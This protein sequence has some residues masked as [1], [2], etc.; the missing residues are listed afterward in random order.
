MT[1]DNL[2][3][4]LDPEQRTATLATG[5]TVVAAGAGS[6]KTRVLTAR[7]L[8]L[9]LE[10]GLPIDKVLALTFTQKAAAEMKSRIHKTLRELEHPLARSVLEGFH[11]AR[12]STID[13]LC[14]AI[15]RSACRQWGIPPDFQ[16][17]DAGARDA[18][19]A[20]AL[21]FVLR[22]RTHPAIKHLLF[23]TE[24]EKIAENLFASLVATHS[25]I[26][27]PIDFRTLFLKQDAEVH[28]RIESAL[29]EASKVM[30]EI[31]RLAQ[32]PSIKTM[33]SIIPISVLT[34]PDT[35]A[36]NNTN[37]LIT[38]RT[39]LSLFAVAP[40]R[41]GTSKQPEAQAIKE[42]L[43]EVRNRHDMECGALISFVLNRDVI[44]GL[45]TLLEEFQTLY[46]TQK[47]QS[48]RLSFA[49]VAKMAVDALATDPELRRSWKAGVDAIMID[50]FQDNN[51]LQRDLLF[52]LAENSTR[53]ETGIPEPKDLCSD[54]LFFVGDEKQSI[55]RFRGADVAVFRALARDLGA[56]SRTLPVLSTNYRTR[57]SLLHQFNMIFPA[58]FDSAGTAPDWE[59]RFTCIQPNRPDYDSPEPIQI[60]VMDHM[61][62]DD[63][64][65]KIKSQIQEAECV[66]RT[67]Q[68]LIQSAVPVFDANGVSH[69]CRADDCAI[70][71]RSTTNQMLFEHS[72]RAAGIPYQ[73]EN[74]RGLFSDAPVN[75]LAALLRTVANPLDLK[76][77]AIVL[78]SPFACL[79]GSGFT[80]A[81]SALKSRDGSQ[82][83]EPA[84][85]SACVDAL[86]TGEDCEQW[87]ALMDLFS[88]AVR[89]ADRIPISE[90]LERLWY[91]RGY[92][93]K[94]LSDPAVR[95]LTALFDYLFELARQADQDGQTLGEFLDRIE[96]I[97][98]NEEKID[99]LDIPIERTGGVRLMTIHKS[100][101]LEFPIVFLANCDTT[102]KN[103]TNSDLV[104]WS[105]VW[106]PT[107]NVGPARKVP[108]K[109]HNWFYL[110][111]KAE[112]E[113]K[114]LAELRRLLYVGMTRAESRLYL[115]GVYKLGGD[116]QESL[117]KQMAEKKPK[118]IKSFFDLF[119][120]VLSLPNA[121]GVQVRAWKE[122]AIKPAA[123]GLFGPSVQDMRTTAKTAVIQQWLPSPRRII[124]TTALADFC[125]S[126]NVQVPDSTE[127]KFFGEQKKKDTEP[128]R[129]GLSATEFGSAAHEAIEARLTGRPAILPESAKSGLEKL[130]D[131][132]L[133]S[134]LGRLTSSATWLKTEF[135]FL[136]R[137]ELSA[138]TITVSGQIDL[139]FE[140][141]GHIHVVDYKTDTV[142][143]PE[144]HRQQ[145]NVYRKAA[146][147]LWQ[148]PVTTWLFYLRSARAVL[149]A[150]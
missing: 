35:P 39:A 69:P 63:G 9:V 108:F 92:R 36:K 56:A 17:D 134:E 85:V 112:E 129:F 45:F 119:T 30:H 67:I 148:K 23:T 12:I 41:M 15:A 126:G 114:A 150:Q 19:R 44:D 140:H 137:W 60:L 93:V 111:G 22:Y 116:G 24:L 62:L 100:K 52:L 147:D 10:K 142:E 61:C 143:N 20:Q 77:W 33:K 40:Q 130:A 145:L 13:S 86:L 81:L 149:V 71:F 29:A 50:E 132:F 2:F 55:Y 141:D 38:F 87:K 90:M 48:G 88:E 7:Y 64:D 104:Y 123:R 46:N 124:P 73:T 79:S 34:A 121:G 49:D 97:R 94:V 14:G 59:A 1:L 139:V 42:L 106:G 18:A 107:I 109:D 125:A 21:P 122:D 120:Q 76:A 47:R 3:A 115:S 103:N 128:Q 51:S 110:Q 96:A 98:R 16:L 105:E 136:T 26:S 43:S 89:W 118:T 133:T 25:P 54:K 28:R 65:K 70:L 117:V 101:G 68:T 27:S 4:I 80:A 138:K 127:R 32:T 82:R 11:Q 144:E 31:C 135:A 131:T 102:G 66:A 99:S 37:E 146:G 84:A 58:I 6:G 83:A 8:H 95:H 57:T 74:A 5:N 75:D 72:L 78:Q 113:S 91:H 53:M